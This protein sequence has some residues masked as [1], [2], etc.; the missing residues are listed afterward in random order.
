MPGAGLNCGASAFLQPVSVAA[1]RASATMRAAEENPFIA[2]PSSR[3]GSRAASRRE[4]AEMLPVSLGKCYRCHSGETAS[5]VPS[6]VMKAFA[7]SA[8]PKTAEGRSLIRQEG[9]IDLL[10]V[11]R[12]VR[13]ARTG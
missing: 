7:A 5:D 10:R 6:Y 13:L 2:S 11:G 4:T 1:T 3:S 9:P 12:D 8:F